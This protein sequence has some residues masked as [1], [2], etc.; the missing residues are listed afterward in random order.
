MNQDYQLNETAVSAILKVGAWILGGYAATS[1]VYAA[2]AELFPPE[3]AEF[4]VDHRFELEVALGNLQAAVF[5]CLRK[6][7]DQI[8][9][10]PTY[11]RRQVQALQ[12]SVNHIIVNQAPIAEF[13]T[14]QGPVWNDITQ[15]TGILFLSAITR[16]AAAKDIFVRQMSYDNMTSNPPEIT[17]CDE[18]KA[19]VL[20]NI[21]TLFRDYIIGQCDLI[22]QMWGDVEKPSAAE[23]MASSAFGGR[24]GYQLPPDYE[25]NPIISSDTEEI[26][27][28]IIYE[29]KDG[30]QE[31]FDAVNAH[32]DTATPLPKTRIQDVP[33]ALARGLWNDGIA[34]L[35]GV[36]PWID[37]TDLAI[38]NPCGKIPRSIGIPG[39][40]GPAVRAFPWEED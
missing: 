9:G 20:R 17:L 18:D 35:F 32:L 23:T 40:S 1:T 12:R 16:N 8:T 33:G 30:M 5:G 26:I 39:F 14:P 24:P 22:D 2:I 31:I 11:R 15:S 4:M 7:V 6:S 28:Y 25:P 34:D 10:Q 3:E 36:L 13:V 27:S 38:A 37:D 21:M 19:R 29:A